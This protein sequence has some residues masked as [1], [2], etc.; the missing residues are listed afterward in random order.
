MVCLDYGSSV[1]AGEF[2]QC[3][4]ISVLKALERVRIKVS[5]K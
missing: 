3:L 2:T 5:V 1:S 4:K